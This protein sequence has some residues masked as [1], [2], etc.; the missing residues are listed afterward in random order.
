MTIKEI[1]GQIQYNGLTERERIKIVIKVISELRKEY[2]II[3][4]DENNQNNLPDK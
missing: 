4:I 1:A 3:P 2:Q